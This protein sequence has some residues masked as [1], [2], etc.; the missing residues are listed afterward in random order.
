MWI[1]CPDCGGK[2]YN[3][4]ILNIKYKNKSI[5]DVLEM[6]VDE[7]LSFFA[8]D[9][10]VTG[11]LSSMKKTG[12]GYIKLGQSA[13]TLSGGEAQRIKLSSELSNDK[14]I[15]TVYVLDEPSSG[16]HPDDVN[17]ISDVFSELTSRGNTVIAIEHNKEIIQNADHIIELGPEGGEKGGYL[18]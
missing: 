13:L 7:A 2:R 4:K 11:I 17:R 5:S 14:T 6:S 15:S 8:E 12:L 9:I 18:M 16:L 10:A 1:T 3:E